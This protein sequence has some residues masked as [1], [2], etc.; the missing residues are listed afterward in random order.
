M[1]QEINKWVST[2]KLDQILLSR[3]INII[4]RIIPQDKFRQF[5]TQVSEFVPITEVCMNKGNVPIVLGFARSVIEDVTVFIADQDPDA[6]SDDEKTFITGNKSIFITAVLLVA[7]A[8][9]NRSFNRQLFLDILPIIS[10]F[11]DVKIT[12]AEYSFCEKLSRTLCCCLYPSAAEEAESLILM[13]P[14]ASS[15]TD[16]VIPAPIVPSSEAVP[17]STQPGETQSNNGG[18]NG[19]NTIM[20]QNPATVIVN[21]SNNELAAAQPITDAINTS[22]NVATSLINESANVATTTVN[23]ATNVAATTVGAALSI[24]STTLN[25]ANVIATTTN[26]VT[27]NVL[28]S[29]FTGLSDVVQAVQISETLAKKRSIIEEPDT[30]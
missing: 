6:I 7:L 14:P 12:F 11:I 23:I 5:A 24:V 1:D 17:N 4:S 28:G 25:N 18:S 3:S 30:D 15:N 2:L 29:I 13:T 16:S 22:A 27:E 20:T 26:N 19:V 9:T 10:Y 21:P 8:Y